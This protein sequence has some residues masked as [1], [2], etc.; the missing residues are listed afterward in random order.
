MRYKL[1]PALLAI[2]GVTAFSASA[3]AATTSKVKPAKG[4]PIKL[5]VIADMDFPEAGISLATA[6]P[7]LAAEAAIKAVNK[8]GG[9]HGHPLK[10]VVDCDSKGDGNVA[11]GC[12]QQAV[13]D[14]VV[15]DVGGFNFAGN[16]AGILQSASVPMIGR[17]PGFDPTEFKNTDEFPFF[18]VGET[19]M[20]DAVYAAVKYLHAKKISLISTAPASSLY[21]STGEAEAKALGATVVNEV[22]AA[23]GSDL[24]SPVLTAEGNGAQAI[25][26]VSPIVDQVIEAA[27]QNGVNLPIVSSL[28]PSQVKELGS[29][30]NGVYSVEPYQL[31]SAKLPGLEQMNRELNAYQS[32]GIPRTVFTLSGWLA[33]HMFA[34]VANKLKVVNRKTVSAAFKRLKNQNAYGLIPNYTTSVKFTGLGGSFPDIYSPWMYLQIDKNGTQV[35]ELGGKPFNPFS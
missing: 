3:G 16:P 32:T 19:G 9:V 8:A 31:P 17:T 25:A 11:N 26:A 28:Q 21:F 33:V 35:P 4:T 14:G 6:R 34:D 29:A 2:A 12:A 22:N 24:T 20:S 7:D 5:S 1:V 27:K 18:A 15:A 30:G 23:P 13:K 10:L